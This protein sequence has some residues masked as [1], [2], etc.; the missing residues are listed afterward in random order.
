MNLQDIHAAMEAIGNLVKRTPL[1]RSRF[2]SEFCDGKVYLKLENEQ[3]TSSFKIRGT[4]NKMLR[5]STKDMKRGI[6]TASAGNHAQAIAIGAEKLKLQAHIVIPKSTPKIKVNK[7][8][9]YDVDLIIHGDFYDQ[10]E[11]KAMNLAKSKKWTYIS[12][13]NDELVIAG[14]G[15]IGLEIYQDLPSVDIVI[16]PVGGGGL[17]SGVSVAVKSINPNIRVL[18]VQSRASPVMCESLKAGEIVNI[19]LRES[20]ADGLY[21]GL[22]K[23]SITFKIVQEYVDNLL[24][25]EEETIMKAISLLWNKEKQ[26]V[27]GAGAVTVALLLEKRGY[28]MGKEV[29]AIVSGG[30]ISDDLFQKILSSQEDYA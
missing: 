19:E 10:A 16:V 13:Y 25:V 2:L 15:T 11:Q 1:L 26:V 7:I 22:E 29:V 20:I 18:G 6:V 28:F 21:G 14:H 27:E 17:I 3:I 23:G 12:P 24:L 8:K 30:N 4:L 5:L 9:K